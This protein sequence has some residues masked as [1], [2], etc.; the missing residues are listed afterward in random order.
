MTESNEPAGLSKAQKAQAGCM[1][2]RCFMTYPVYDLLFPREIEREQGLARLFGAVP[3]SH[4]YLWA[5]GA[6][7]GC[8]GRGIGGRLLQLVLAQADSDGLPCYLET[9]AERNLAFYQK[10]GFEVLNDD[11]MPGPT[12]SSS[13]SALPS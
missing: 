8:Q 3:G 9:H 12:P 13:W 1:M 4:W 11:L 10:W 5:L 2:A 6:E 7:P